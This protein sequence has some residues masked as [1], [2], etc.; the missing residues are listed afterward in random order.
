MGD[1]LWWVL[2]SGP[3]S[4]SPRLVL[5]E[6]SPVG[7]LRVQRDD[8][9]GAVDGLDRVGG[10][11]R[12]VVVVALPTGSGWVDPDQVAV[13]EEWA[14]GDV[15]T[16]TARYSRAPS[17]AVYLLRPDLADA[18]TRE[19]LGAVV[20]RIDR[21][22]VGE[23]PRVVV[24]GQSLGAW[25]GERAVAD[26]GVGRVDAV[27]WQGAPGAARNDGPGRSAGTV[28]DRCVVDARNA[29]DPV[30]HLHP[31]LLWDPRARTGDALP[32][33]P[34]VSFL[35]V[36]AALPGSLDAPAGRGHRYRPVLPPEG[37]AGGA[38][39]RVGPG[40][41]GPGRGIPRGNHPRGID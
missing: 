15:T 34:V 21:M 26:L 22:P 19:L 5:T 20:G 13:L 25:A 4:S 10:L 11:R 30:V 39:T 7:A 29:D 24:H 8:V 27:M 32:W 35:R 38:G 16:V 1:A 33:L 3:A 17:A 14:G 36:A 9:A 18:A 40:A 41:H 6:P 2:D 12:S 37:C 23:R 28:A 31:D